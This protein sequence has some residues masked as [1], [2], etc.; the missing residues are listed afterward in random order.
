MKL[1]TARSR[2]LVGTLA[3]SIAS[4]VALAAVR[5]DAP[6][7]D[8]PPPAVHPAIGEEPAGMR[9]L[10]E[11]ALPQPRGQREA[12]TTLARPRLAAPQR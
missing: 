11:Q 12:G 5:V 7:S 1:V 6:A 2:V 3:L 9:S 10:V 8:Q 4:A